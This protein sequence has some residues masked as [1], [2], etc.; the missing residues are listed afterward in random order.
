MTVDDLTDNLIFFSFSTTIISQ[1]LPI[2]GNYVAWK[3]LV[4]HVYIFFLI[5]NR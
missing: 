1:K 2:L 3:Y 4:K 5:F